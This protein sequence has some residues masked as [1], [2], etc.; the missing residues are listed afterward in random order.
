MF[1]EGEDM[2]GRRGPRIGPTPEE[3]AMLPE[4]QRE[5]ERMLEE[6]A[7]QVEVGCLRGSAKPTLTLTVDSPRECELV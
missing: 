4:M 2:E 7:Q 6:E 5:R 1:F 3:N